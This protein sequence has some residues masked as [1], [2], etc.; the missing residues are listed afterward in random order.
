MRKNKFSSAADRRW[1]RRYERIQRRKEEELDRLDRINSD[2]ELAYWNDLQYAYVLPEQVSSPTVTVTLP[3]F[4]E[5]N[6]NGTTVTR[7]AYG[8]AMSEFSE[9]NTDPTQRSIAEALG[10]IAHGTVNN[11]DIE[12]IESYIHEHVY[13]EFQRAEEENRARQLQDEAYIQLTRHN[14][15]RGYRAGAFVLDDYYEPFHDDKSDWVDAFVRV[16]DYKYGDRA[17]FSFDLADISPA[18]VE[19][20]AGDTAQLDSFLE[21]FLS[22]A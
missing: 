1:Q 2:P 15:L 19:L 17:M 18:E 9:R 20:E 13:R 4:D 8:H 12:R 14:N 21:G 10:N 3:R 7:E 6:L 11:D 22:P 16:A 5:P